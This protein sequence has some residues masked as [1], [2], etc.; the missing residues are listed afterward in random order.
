GN[1]TITLLDL[2]T[3]LT[4]IY[5]GHTSRLTAIT[6][7]TKEIPILLSADVGVAI[8][9]WPLPVEFARIAMT[10]NSQFNTAAFDKQSRMVIAT[11]FFPTLTT[12]SPSTGVRT[13]T[14]HEPHNIYLVQSRGGRVFA[15]Y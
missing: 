3:D 11:T 5:K 7:P 9:A 2:R 4:S 13:F 6:P 14:P 8:R 15:T 12:F 10:M 1:G